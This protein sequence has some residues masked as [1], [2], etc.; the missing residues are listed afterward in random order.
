MQEYCF[1]MYKVLLM[2]LMVAVVFTL[3]AYIV[4]GCVRVNSICTY[5]DV[6]KEG[7]T[8][9]KDGVAVDGEKLVAANYRISINDEKK[10]VY[11]SDIPYRHFYYSNPVVVPYR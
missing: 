9:Y 5:D 3:I 7:Y 10:E 11:L 4:F 1:G 6:V 8:V 2:V